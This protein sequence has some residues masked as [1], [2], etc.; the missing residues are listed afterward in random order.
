V[1]AER[2]KDWKKKGRRKSSKKKTEGRNKE[3]G[4]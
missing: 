1:Y 4:E 2:N 3:T